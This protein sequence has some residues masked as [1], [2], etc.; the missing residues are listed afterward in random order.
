MRDDDR[1]AT[2]RSGTAT[3]E[4]EPE[5]D[6]QRD[7]QAVEPATHPLGTGVG[8]AGGAATGAAIGAAVGGPAGAMVGA[9]V[10]GIAGGFAG[11]G[12]AEA[13]NPTVEDAFWR[14]NHAQRPYASGRTYDELRPAYKYGWET[15]VQHPGRPFQHAEVDLERGWE[16][17]RGETKLRW[18]EARDA[19]RDAW[20]R[21]DARAGGR[22]D[23]TR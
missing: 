22:P 2:H 23:P 17:V 19:V 8:A 12:I 20:D 4:A 5:V 15:R 10:G 6:P 7:P 9:A 14:E 21:I 11:K 1:N 16:R 18:R 13:V 3:L